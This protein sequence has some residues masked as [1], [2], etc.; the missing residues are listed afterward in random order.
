VIRGQQRIHPTCH[1]HSPNM[2]LPLTRHA[3]PTH[4]TCH[5]HSPDMPLPLTQHATPTHPTCYFSSVSNQ[6]LVKRLWGKEFTS[7]QIM[8]ARKHSCWY[9]NASRKLEPANWESHCLAGQT[10]FRGGKGIFVYY[11]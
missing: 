9:I 1:S 10:F 11:R 4:P 6:D 3:T 5:S 8:C 2:P 7:Q